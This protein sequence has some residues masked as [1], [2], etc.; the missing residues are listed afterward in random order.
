MHL[1]CSMSVVADRE[2]PAALAHI[3]ELGFR[4]FDL[5][6]LERYGQVWP[7][8]L[9]AE[10]PWGALGR[11]IVRASAEAG[12]QAASFN[13][14]FSQPVNDPAPEARRVVEAEFGALL[15][16]AE[17]MGCPNLTLQVGGRADGVTA[18]EALDAARA[19]LERLAEL[20]GDSVGLSFEPHQGSVA[21][22]PRDALSLAR[23]LWPG[24]GV[25]YDPSHFVMQPEVGSLVESE[26]LLEYTRH[27]HLR[28][29]ARGRMQAPM[30]EGEVDFGWVIEALRG[31]GYE[32][33]VAIEYLEAAEADALAL[34]EVLL[35]LGV[36]P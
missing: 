29:A 36:S 23:R 20:A 11:A 28:N 9:A 17:E 19:G 22:R 10:G 6:A 26:P 18:A 14:S 16:L 24:V 4:R 3:A 5:F 33:A 27:V 35:G 34:R 25:T 1:S 7:S 2:A 15:S 13:C 8:R 30:A 32:G 31:R 21:E 12:L